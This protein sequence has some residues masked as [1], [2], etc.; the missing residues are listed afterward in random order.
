MQITA[1]PSLRRRR[2]LL[3]AAGAAAVPLG[4]SSRM[5][6]AAPGAD[7]DALHALVERYMD[8]LLDDDPFYA[9][10]LGLASA[11]QKARIPWVIAPAVRDR[12]DARCR[13][14]LRAL[15]RIDRHRLDAADG[16]AA[17]V[18]QDH[19]ADVLAQHRFPTHLLPQHQLDSTLLQMASAADNGL[20]TFATVED[21]EG[22][23]ARLGQLPAWC[24]QAGA[25]FREGVRRGIVWPRV[26]VER[27]LPMVRALAVPSLERNPLG[28]PAKR[29]PASATPAQRQRLVDAYR[30]VLVGKV[31]PAVAGLAGTLESD[32][33]PHARRSAGFGDLPDGAAWYAQLVRS[34]TTT[35]MDPKEI[36]AL[37]LA[38]VQRLRGEMAKVQ[39]HYGFSGPLDAFMRWHDTRPEERPFRSEADVLAAYEALNRRIAPQLPALFGRVPK[40]GLEIRPEPELT[41]DTASDH[42]VP[43]SPGGA[44]PGVFYAVIPD[45]RQYGTARMT[46]LFLHEGQ[47]GHHY[48]MALAQELPIT[49]LQRFWFYDS[50]GEG[51]A[52]YA[53]TL[54]HRLGLYDDP[55]AY[56]GHLTLAMLRAVRLV[57][58]TGLHDRGWTRER[59]MAY[60]SDNTGFP[61]QVSRAQIERYMVAP[62]QALSYAIGRMKIESLRDRAS[63]ALGARFSLASF[64]DEVLGS[65]SLPLSV[66]ER[67]I[68]RWISASD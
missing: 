34:S 10:T 47:P 48:Q 51:W 58:D 37:G 50:Y 66:L 41:R 22:H 33:L 60:L 6:G 39:A 53:E 1:T 25:N 42:Y 32:V 28:E 61:E 59:A 36:H 4:C 16:I 30:E 7:A 35:N 21:H 38:E 8:G 40:A 19:A 67:K 62:G 45:P 9:S 27:T 18:L 13:D 17:E 15:E 3:A 52:L 44:R 14:T 23:L 55:N 12:T 26:I 57:V 31:V 56:L 68:E 29:I 64:H 2:L 63:A 43:P 46:T 24:E 20:S 11:E 49:R 54:G 65:G 5:P